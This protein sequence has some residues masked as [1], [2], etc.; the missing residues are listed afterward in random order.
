MIAASASPRKTMAAAIAH[1]L[2]ALR[3]MLAA[4][5]S[6]VAMVEFAFTAPIVLTMGLL[7]AETAYFTVMHL[8]ISQAAMQVADNAS[9]IGEMDLLVAR[10]V[11]ERDVNDVF[12]G[13]EKF[14]ESFR[15]LNNGRIILSSLQ[16][17]NDGGQTIRWQRCRGA[18]V[19]NSSFGVQGVGATGTSFKGMGE[20]G[21]Q[22]QASAGTAVMFV[23]VAYDYQPLTP[24]SMFAGRE[25]RYT[26]A[27]N[28]RD[29]RDL[30]NIFNTNPAGPVA[31]CDVYSAA[32]PT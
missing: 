21:R 26:A 8:R 4:C 2:G 6:G 29:Q 31:R 30:T 5:T 14:G 1:R 24:Y 25:I 23:E 17:N 9:R 12:V 13:A 22:I 28:I 15:L 20:A 19:F 3:S 11:F 32:R 10:Q 27:M 7:G 18:K 16:R